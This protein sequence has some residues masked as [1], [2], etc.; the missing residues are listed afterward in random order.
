MPQRSLLVDLREPVRSPRRCISRIRKILSRRPDTEHEIT[1]NRLAFSGVILLYMVVG[2]LWEAEHAKSMLRESYLAISFYI[3][4]SLAIF[5]HILYRPGISVGRRLISIFLDL[6]IISFGGIAGGEGSGFL[7]PLYLWTILGNGFRF[8]I[9]YLYVAMGVALVGFMTVLAVT[10]YWSQHIGMS[11][12]LLVGLVMLPAYV[13]RLIR[14]LSEAK[15]QAEEA[16]RAKSLFLASVSHE[17]R[18]P[19]NAIIGLSGLLEDQR[20]GREQADM[21]RTIGTSGRSLLGLINSILDFSRIEAGRMPSATVDFD[22]Y[23]MAHQV[24]SML[25][26]QAQPK[27][28]QLT[29]HMTSRT[30]RYVAASLRH[31]EEVL[32]NL[33]GNAVKFTNSGYVVIGVDAIRRE[34]E[35]V[36]LRFEVSDTGIGIAPEAQ[37]RIFESFT[38]ADETIIDRFG[39]TGLGLAI[40]KQLVELM[41]GE[42]GVASIPGAGSTFWFEIDAQAQPSETKPDIAT[43]GPIVVLSRD[44]DLCRMLGEIVHDLDVVHSVEELRMRLSLSASEPLA[45]LLDESAVQADDAGVDTI[46][47]GMPQRCP[48]MILIMTGRSEAMLPDDRRRRYASAIGRPLDVAEVRAALAIA[49]ANSGWTADE[50]AVQTAVLK[51]K[52]AFSVLVAEDNRTNQIVL[53][54]ILERAGHRVTLVNDGEGALDALSEGSFDVVLMD[55]N[56]PVMN[57]IDAAKLYRFAA[58]DEERVP[59]IALTADA[60]PEARARCKEAGMDACATKP[61]EPHALLDLIESIVPH[62]DQESALPVATSPD[63]PEHTR[64][65]DLQGEA[66]QIETLDEL[67]RLG[68]PEF[69]AELAT[70]FVSDAAGVLRALSKSVAE[71]DVQAFREQVHALRS[72]AANV[73]AQ[74]MFQMCLAWREI[75]AR[76]LALEGETYMRRLVDEFETV[77]AMLD[78]HVASRVTDR[79]Q[80]SIIPAPT[81]RIRRSA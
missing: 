43:D 34:D 77:Q 22:L 25:A 40:C 41:G 60:T 55:V 79:D 65:A 17:L 18:T 30:P 74:N 48:P 5:G 76:E 51:A 6:G 32:V 58:L 35:T 7:Y 47:A 20:L 44:E 54:K 23:A 3:A 19:L 78:R 42:I 75:G 12:A 15:R 53:A 37:R 71:E 68:G 73:G 69:V 4:A 1:L 46:V 28:L 36:R 59:I 38:Q 13:S 67:E 66:I 11:V 21:V 50:T 81:T 31:L 27:G 56:M 14:K 33:G 72:C 45:I 61:I 57:G 62:R 24:R 39:G 2:T 10:G 29:V 52:R 63:S 8:G 16:S 80:A 49:S 26:V 9:A 64:D 70:Q